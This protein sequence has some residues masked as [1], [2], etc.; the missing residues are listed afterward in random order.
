MPSYNVD[1]SELEG[2][3]KVDAAVA[4]ARSY[5]GDDRKFETILMVAASLVA[6]TANMGQARMVMSFAGIQGYPV[7]ALCEYA[8][9]IVGGS[10]PEEAEEVD[11]EDALK[12]V[13]F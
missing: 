1:Y 3:E 6:G 4:D 9:R 13:K 8:V 7:I 10:V 11:I 2:A 5:V 12:T